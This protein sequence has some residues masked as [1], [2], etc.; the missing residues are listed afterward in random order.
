MSQDSHHEAYSSE[1]SDTSETQPLRQVKNDVLQDFSDLAGHPS[2][3][4]WLQSR[5]ISSNAERGFQ[6]LHLLQSL[7]ADRLNFLQRALDQLESAEQ[8]RTR[9]T[10]CALEELDL[11][12]HKC[13]R[14]LALLQ[15]VLKA[16]DVVATK[17]GAAQQPF[18][19]EGGDAIVS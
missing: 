5:L 8:A 1:P 9:L 10:R 19:Q 13:E 11:E 7:F 12:I 6:P 18:T 4:D 15:G 2:P 3:P 16:V 17:E 14:Y